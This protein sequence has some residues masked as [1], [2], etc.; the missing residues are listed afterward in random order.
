MCTGLWGPASFCT[1]LPE[2]LEFDVSVCHGREGS[3]S[4]WRQQ[5]R[6]LF[7]RKVYQERCH[8]CSPKK[9]RFKVYQPV[10]HK[11]LLYRGEH[12]F[13]RNNSDGHGHRT[14]P[15]KQKW[16]LY[17]TEISSVIIVVFQKTVA[18]EAVYG[19]A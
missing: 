15:A 17:C 12:G 7:Y 5:A 10:S 8:H 1:I 18:Q 6:S 14:M 16:Y 3:L 11:S 13:V 2:A 19:G 9:Y 4:R